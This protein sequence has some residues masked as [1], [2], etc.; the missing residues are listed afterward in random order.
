LKINKTIKNPSK[1]TDTL[2]DILT[3]HVT[4][5]Q[6]VYISEP[7]ELSYNWIERLNYKILSITK[8][9]TGRL[10]HNATFM[11]S[12]T[13]GYILIDGEETVSVD[14]K[15][16]H[17]YLLTSMISTISEKMEWENILTSGIYEYMMNVL[18]TPNREYCKVI[19]QKWISGKYN[20]KGKTLIAVWNRKVSQICPSLVK[21]LNDVEQGETTIQHILQNKE[22][23]VVIDQ[24]FLGLA[25]VGIFTIPVHDCLICKKSDAKI[26]KQIME[27]KA[28]K[29]WGITVKTSIK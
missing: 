13:R 3:N 15:S 1:A 26:I 19:F 2:K 16:L 27:E 21:A 12:K 9:K 5:N 22:A 10:Y 23:I 20:K 25:G 7:S 29:V 4:V 18:G 6:S 24:I 17:P 11:D 28:L 14:Y 8:G